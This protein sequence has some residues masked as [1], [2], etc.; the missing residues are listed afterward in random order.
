MYGKYC[1][2]CGADTGPYPFAAHGLKT[3]AAMLTNV[4]TPFLLGPTASHGALPEY[5]VLIFAC[6]CVLAG[7]M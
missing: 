2:N 6:T 5:R 4:A 3:Q 1:M 7:E